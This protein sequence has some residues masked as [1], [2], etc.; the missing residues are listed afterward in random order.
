MSARIFSMCLNPLKSG[1]PVGQMRK[2]VGENF[3]YVSQSPQIGASC[4]T[5][6]QGDNFQYVAHVSIP[7]NRGVLSDFSNQHITDPKNKGLNPLKSGRPVGL[8]LGNH[9]A[10]MRKWSQSPQI[11]ASC[12]TQALAPTNR[13]S[14]SSQSPQIGASCRTYGIAS[15]L[16]RC[17]LSQSPQIGAS[18]RT[19]NALIAALKRLKSLNPLKSG[20]PVGLHDLRDERVVPYHVSIPSNR[21]VLSD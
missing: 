8:R 4:R 11:G 6:W 21:G 20:R 1:R 14:F 15:A 16:I 13:R 9:P 2:Y 7:S 18:C 19:K 10:E 12:R 5:K 3:Q 17:Y